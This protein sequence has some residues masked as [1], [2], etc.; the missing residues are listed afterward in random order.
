MIMPG[1]SMPTMNYFFSFDKFAHAFVF[2]I[3]VLLLIVS[4]T[5]QYSSQFFRE[6]A[7]FLGISLTVIYAVGI[8]FLQSLIPGR[9][10]EFMDIVADAAG[11]F[12]GYF[13]FYII[14]KV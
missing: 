3:Q 8:E 13:L 9:S 2:A 4:F 5:K 6:N 7:V 12:I 11:C 1:Q 14:Y 10:L